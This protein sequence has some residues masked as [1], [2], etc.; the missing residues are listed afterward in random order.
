MKQDR[1]RLIPVFYPVTPSTPRRLLRLLGIISGQTNCF[2]GGSSIKVLPRFP[3]FSFSMAVSF[4]D[5]KSQSV[6]MVHLICLVTER[7]EGIA[8]IVTRFWPTL[9]VE[10]SRNKRRLY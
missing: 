8:L 6:H 1:R 9:D 4:G 10:P 5:S 3:N 7:Q 2:N